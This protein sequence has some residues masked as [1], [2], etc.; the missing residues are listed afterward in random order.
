MGK[1][2]VCFSQ[3]DI[4]PKEETGNVA[5]NEVDLFSISS[6]VISNLLSMKNAQTKTTRKSP[7]AKAKTASPSTSR[8]RKKNGEDDAS[9]QDV[10]E[11][12]GKGN[13]NPKGKIKKKMSSGSKKKNG[14]QKL[15]QAVVSEEDALPS[16][17]PSSELKANDA[18]SIQE[19]FGD[20][21][22]VRVKSSSEIRE[23][24]DVKP[25]LTYEF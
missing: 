7:R 5:E 21:I 18:K 23:P 2:F 13:G 6:S 15:V 22:T 19:M 10:E 20:R 24:P 25:I 1:K 3:I 9:A 17:R 8:K 16:L 12:K 11:A 4:M 14:K